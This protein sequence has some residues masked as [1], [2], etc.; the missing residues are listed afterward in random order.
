MHELKLL[1]KIA[2]AVCAVIVCG[3]QH[4]SSGGTTSIEKTTSLIKLSECASV[5]FTPFG[6]T[7]L[8]LF[9]L[10][11]KKVILSQFGLTT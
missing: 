10:L 11:V 6:L 8:I 9:Y 1:E 4:T 2:N 3:L 5:W 7:A